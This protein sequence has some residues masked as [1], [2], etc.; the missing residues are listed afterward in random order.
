MTGSRACQRQETMEEICP[1]SLIVGNLLVK[2]DGSMKKKILGS[3]ESSVA[4]AT[5]ASSIYR[6]KVRSDMCIPDNV[7]QSRNVISLT[8]CIVCRQMA[9]THLSVY[10]FITCARCFTITPSIETSG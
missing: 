10:R 6:R 5:Q 4:I 8:N 1:C 2:M 3:V 9:E 7:V